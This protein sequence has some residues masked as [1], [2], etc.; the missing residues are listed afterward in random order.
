MQASTGLVQT[1]IGVM[2]RR[3]IPP[4]PAHLPG[5]RP[6]DPQCR[7]PMRFCTQVAPCKIRHGHRRRIGPGNWT[8]AS[9]LVTVSQSWPMRMSS[10]PSRF[11]KTI[12]LKLVRS[13]RIWAPIRG[14]ARAKKITKL[15]GVTELS[16]SNERHPAERVPFYTGIPGRRID[17]S[18]SAFLA[19]R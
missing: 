6:I 10:A 13:H 2:P 4:T 8:Y 15:I 1:L 9:I 12:T 3:A 19:S 16:R 11:S 5:A 14:F 7:F 18:S 17:P